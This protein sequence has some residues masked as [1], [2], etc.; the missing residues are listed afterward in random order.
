MSATIHCDH[1]AEYFAGDFRRCKRVPKAVLEE[2]QAEDSEDE[3]A[4]K[5]GTDTKLLDSLIEGIGPVEPGAELAA[6]VRD[7]VA[8]TDPLPA[9]L[10]AVLQKCGWEAQQ[11]AFRGPIH[12]AQKADL[13]LDLSRLY[14]VHAPAP[15]PEASDDDME[16]DPNPDPAEG[17]GDGLPEQPP[18][19]I[20]PAPVVN[21]SAES[22]FKVKEY[23]LSDVVHD[24][25]MDCRERLEILSRPHNM[26]SKVNARIDEDRK[27]L[28]FKYFMYL[29]RHKHA[30]NKGTYLLFLPGGALIMEFKET[31]MRCTDGGADCDFHTLHSTV[32]IEDQQRVMLPPP[33]GKRKVILSTNIAESSITVP[34]VMAVIDFCL[35]KTMRWDT[36]T[37]NTTLDEVWASKSSAEQRAGRAGRVCDGEVYRWVTKREY[38]NFDVEPEPQI[39]QFPLDSMILKL[40]QIKWGEPG[41]LLA[42]TID[43]PDLKSIV[44]S[45]QQL[46]DIGAVVLDRTADQGEEAM[47]EQRLA[48][49][50]GVT[51][52]ELLSFSSRYAVTKIGRVI[53]TLAAETLPCMLILYG[54]AFGML[55]ECL[56][57]AS[58]VSQ[59]S[60]ILNP[61]GR[62]LIGSRAMIHYAQ[63]SQSDLIAGLHGYRYW[64]AC[65]KKRSFDLEREAEWC[66]ENRLSLFH[67]REMEDNV[68]RPAPIPSSLP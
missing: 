50:H 44:V 62:P 3:G 17:Q 52:Q 13:L 63:Y 64:Q 20:D 49:R 9:E 8:E 68:V 29:H 22:P 59:K 39:K 16:T 25:E 11:R 32:P 37:Q 57:L 48:S 23:Y 18:K 10:C 15:G 56:V 45:Y 41:L 4:D 34:D 51:E 26:L 6:T 28:F 36:D 47:L 12:P 61:T 67:L 38:D 65:R 43:P 35:V 42:Q 46:I 55:D 24:M 14:R 21:L 30:D 66:R 58:I 33:P 40:L 54:A 53:A 1:F 31:L 2:W 60:P 7:L 19:V 5:P 27:E